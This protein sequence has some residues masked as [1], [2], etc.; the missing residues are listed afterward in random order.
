MKILYKNTSLQKLRN[1]ESSGLCSNMMF[2]HLRR[3]FENRNVYM[4]CFSISIYL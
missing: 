2:V 3:D 4:L 1:Q